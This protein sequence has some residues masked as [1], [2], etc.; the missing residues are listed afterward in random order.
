MEELVMILLGVHLAT[1]CARQKEMTRP[2]PVVWVTSARLRLPIIIH[3][4]LSVLSNDFRIP[5]GY[6]NVSSNSFV[7][8]TR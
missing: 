6:A 5:S 4:W 2:A 3:D 1:L 8:R 7:L